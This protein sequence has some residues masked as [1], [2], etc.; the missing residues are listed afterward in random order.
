MKKENEL[1][2][3]LGSTDY[4]SQVVVETVMLVYS[5]QNVSQVVVEA[6]IR[7]ST[8]KFGPKIQ[9]I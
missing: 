7:E 1:T 8:D 5:D 3:K 2:P 9:V 4:I 6:V